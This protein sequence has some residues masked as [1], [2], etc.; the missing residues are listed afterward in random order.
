[1]ALDLEPIRTLEPVYI[2]H[3]RDHE[4][5]GLRKSRARCEL[6]RDGVRCGRGRFALPH[7]GHPRSMN[8]GGS[9]WNHHVWQAEKE[10]WEDR[11]IDLLDETDLPRCLERVMVEGVICFP[12][13]NKRDQGNLRYPIE[14]FLGDALI[15]GGWLVP[16]KKGRGHGRGDEWSRFTFGNLDAVWSPGRSFLRLM[17]MPDNRPIPDW[18]PPLEE[19]TW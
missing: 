19:M 2:Q 13:R 15:K 17:L 8:Q 9:G 10:T 1:M 14:K 4:F 11:F 7:L 16:R 6:V 5:V 3:D 12:D 18:P